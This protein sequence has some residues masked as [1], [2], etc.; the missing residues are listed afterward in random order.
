MRLKNT[1]AQD[2][3]QMELAEHIVEAKRDLK[4]IQVKQNHAKRFGCSHMERITKHLVEL[5]PVSC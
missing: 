2:D 4:E 5:H 1:T 3:D